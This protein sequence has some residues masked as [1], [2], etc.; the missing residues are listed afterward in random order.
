MRW[1]NSLVTCLV[2]GSM[3]LV[4]LLDQAATG[5]PP[6]PKP[7]P[8]P[9]PKKLLRN[10]YTTL[11][12]N[13][14]LHPPLHTVP[15]ARKWRPGGPKQLWTV[16]LGR[17]Y[18]GAVIDRGQVFVLDRVHDRRDVLR[19]LDLQTGR[20]L[21]N[22]DW[23]AP[24]VL[25][26]DGSRIQTAVDKD[27]VYC[28]GPMGDLYCVSRTTH[29]PVWSHH[30]RKEFYR[31]YVPRWGYTQVPALY[32]NMV[33]V[34]PMTPTVG[35]VA[36]DRKTGKLCWTSRNL[37][38]TFFSHV[39]PY[40]TRLCGIDQ[41]IMLGN[42]NRRAN[43]PAIISGVSASTGQLLWQTHTWKRY[44]MP[45]PQPVRVAPDT[46]FIAGGYGIGCFG[47]RVTRQ[48]GLWGTQFTFKDDMNC[49]PHIHTPLLYQG[50]I[51]AQSFDAYHNVM[52]NGLVC[53]TPGG[54]L[55]WKSGPGQL[56][57]S[58]P[59]LIADGLIF[60]LHGKTGELFLVEATPDGYHP[61]DHAKVL[62]AKGG[63]A[64]APMA[65]SP[66]GKLVLRDLHE[67]KCLDVS[68]ADNGSAKGG[69]TVEPA[70]VE[71]R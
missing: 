47:L 49:T 11:P 30:F 64:W 31:G 18:A 52:N 61:L 2:A 7:K 3:L 71:R 21:W 65:I 34:G 55:L 54:T 16:Q 20:E 41:V 15:L 14:A 22:C 46:L 29:R 4:T 38:T 53:L 44:N 70:N 23:R 50:Y 12:D 33:I 17:G 27:H 59:L 39:S 8:K 36:Y 28:L 13:P 51:Y 60:V 58:G 69:Q 19:C 56:F 40:V 37:G 10:M 45:I 62:P 66:D 42:L 32:D 48:S 6:A 1:R 26:W 9:V 5:A 43:P 24:G 63:N 67:M 35:L 25:P 57:G 68:A